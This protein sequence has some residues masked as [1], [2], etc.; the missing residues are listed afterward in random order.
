MPNRR[1]V[2]PATTGVL[3]EIASPDTIDPAILPNP[4]VLA[5]IGTP[6]SP[7]PAGED[8]YYFKSDDHLYTM[9][10]AGVET[11]VGSGGG[12]GKTFAFFMGA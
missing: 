10:S 7:P 4:G 3:T 6:A 1:P 8:Y 5:Q 12:G 2:Y 9:N 11:Q